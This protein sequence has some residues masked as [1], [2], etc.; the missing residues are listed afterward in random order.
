MHLKEGRR[1]EREKRLHQSLENIQMLDD[2]I[3]SR[4]CREC[5]TKTFEHLTG[6][7]LDCENVR[8]QCG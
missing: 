1:R 2:E 6:R 4:L 7:E 8:E 3:Y 5:Q